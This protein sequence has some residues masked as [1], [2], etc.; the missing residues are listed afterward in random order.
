MGL[1][2]QYVNQ[3]VFDAEEK[4]ILHGV[5]AQGIVGRGLSSEMA[6]RYPESMLEFTEFKPILGNIQV[7]HCGDKS[8]INAVICNTY[9]REK[10]R[11]VNYEALASTMEI[12]EDRLYGQKIA[13]PLIG[14]GYQFGNW[15]IIASIIEN[16]LQ[17]VMPVVYVKSGEY[18]TG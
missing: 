8:I 1:R 14:L 4:F 5:N 6:K 7:I 2:I 17:T 18:H 11:Y 3:N 10:K 16:T 9:G 15:N 12:L 13:M